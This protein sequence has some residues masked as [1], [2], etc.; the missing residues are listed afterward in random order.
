M[1]RTSRE[2]IRHDGGASMRAYLALPDGEPP[3]EGWPGVIVIHDAFGFSSDVRRITR[4]FADSGY[5]AIAPALYD[6][7]G[8][9]VVC[10]VR[11]FG[12]L[13][14]RRGAAFE[15]I[16]STRRFLADRDEVNG[17]R[18]GVT[19]FCMG[20][21]FALFYAARG[22]VQVCAPYYGDTPAEAETLRSVCPVVAGFGELDESFARQGRRLGEHL[23]S[24]G[25]PHDVKIYPGV[26]H[27]YMNDFGS[28]PLVHLMRHTPLHAG[29]DEEAAE[30]SWRRM[31]A[32]FEKH[33]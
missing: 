20:G 4:R 8:P 21:G 17:D 7:A 11:T 14:R 15:R 30:D 2:T 5:A 28:G 32:F 16:E 29:Y 1:T 27:G 23:S 25:I 6:G 12:D 31:L 26:G 18:I 22:G 9:P 33:L 13:T 10:V 19:G 24:L 3:A